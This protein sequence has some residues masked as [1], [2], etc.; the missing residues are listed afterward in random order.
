MAC[1][2]DRR[3]ELVVES[4]APKVDQSNVY[5]SQDVLLLGP[6]DLESPRQSFSAC[7]ARTYH[8]SRTHS[9]S[10]GVGSVF[11]E[12]YVLGFEIRMNQVQ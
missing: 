7:H 6:L 5:V 11:D 9:W 10:Q 4:R 8:G 1:A 3:M 12:Q 2:N